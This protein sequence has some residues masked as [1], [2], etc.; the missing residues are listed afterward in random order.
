MTDERRQK[1]YVLLVF[2]ASVAVTLL[3]WS[4]LPSHHRQNEST[5]YAHFYEPVA[6]RLLSGEGMTEANGALALRYPPGYPM[7]LAGVFGVAQGLRLPESMVLAAMTTIC[8]GLA[9][10]SVFYMAR[11]V[12]QPGAALGVA[13]V[14]TTYPC[15]LWL[16]K[17]PNSE[18]PFCLSFYG[19]M[20]LLMHALW[21]GPR[22]RNYCYVL[23]GVCLGLGMLIRPIAIGFGAV[24]CAMVWVVHR[25]AKP[26]QLLGWMLLLWLGITI[27]VLPWE[28]WVYMQ[29]GRWILLSDNGPASILDGFVFTGI[30]QAP[31]RAGVIPP[32]VERL[33]QALLNETAAMTSLRDIGQQVL[34]T[35]QAEPWTMSKLIG[36]KLLR[37]WYGTDSMRYEGLILTMQLIYVAMMAWSGWQ[38]WRRGGKSWQ[39]SLCVGVS[40][41]YFWGMTALVVPLVRYMTPVMG[42][43]FMLLPMAWSSPWRAACDNTHD[44]VLERLPSSAA[45]IA[46]G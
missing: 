25:G 12:W 33:G 44:V 5:D 2:A 17:Q 43:G 6:R 26:W 30:G 15:L 13:L 29:T 19:G 28:G 8:T 42:L 10:V 24:A 16:T 27:T 14:W 22:A 45:R 31:L 3:F 11:S 40:I 38:A 7:L 4:V 34:Q 20:A 32:D 21:T 46:H 36:L 18:L 41:L 23:A 37:S 39:L 1:R 9:S 35:W